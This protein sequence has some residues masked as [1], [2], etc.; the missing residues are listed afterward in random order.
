MRE[1]G[2]NL[3]AIAVRDLEAEDY[4]HDETKYRDDGEYRNM[5][6]ASPPEWV[7]GSH[8]FKETKKGTGSQN[9]EEGDK[10]RR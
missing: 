2:C 7:F 3:P 4:G 8:E 10:H 1:Q 6:I 5:L 9:E